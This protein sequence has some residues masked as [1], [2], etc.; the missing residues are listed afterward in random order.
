[1][2][3]FQNFKNIDLQK[4][5]NVKTERILAEIAVFLIILVLLFVT[6]KIFTSNTDE[7]IP[8]FQ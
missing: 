7:E 5:E 8:D 6:I 2:K 3:L 1:M 4:F